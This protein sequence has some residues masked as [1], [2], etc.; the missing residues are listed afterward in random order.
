MADVT[1]DAPGFVAINFIQCEEEY[2]GRFEELFQSRA[3]AIDRLPGF[4]RMEVLR[5]NG[6][7]G[8]YLVV[9]HWDSEDEF[10][11]WTSS[12][13]FLE[14]H[15]RG[16]EDLRKAK[17]EGRRPPMKSTFKTYSVLCR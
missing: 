12:P 15:K 3:H 4:R 6:E 10:Q 16:F 5:P 9:S 17:E 8:E 1:T 7:E 14:G 13:E 2:R 11:T